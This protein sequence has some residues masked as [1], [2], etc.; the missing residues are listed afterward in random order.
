MINQRLGDNRQPLDGRG[1]GQLDALTCL[2]VVHGEHVA[3]RRPLEAGLHDGFELPREQVA[4]ELG[5]YVQ[6][7]AIPLPNARGWR[8]LLAVEEGQGVLDVVCTFGGVR[9]Q[10]D[11]PGQAAYPSNPHALLEVCDEQHMRQHVG[12]ETR[13][14]GV[15]LHHL[16]LHRAAGNGKALRA[17]VSQHHRATET[18]NQTQLTA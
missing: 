9:E 6:L 11:V 17:A 13:G 15:A 12:G 18:T 8:S 5:Q 1:P 4:L 3:A 7:F 14:G 10:A 16:V 2:A